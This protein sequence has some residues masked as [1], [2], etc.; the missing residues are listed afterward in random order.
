[1]SE[2]PVKLTDTPFAASLLTNVP[3]ALPTS[4]TSSPVNGLPSS[5]L[6]APAVIVACKT[7]VP[8][9]AAV[10]LPSYSFCEADSPLMVSA[11]VVMFAVAVGAPAMVSE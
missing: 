7:G 5:P 8:V 6:P 11:L 10:K 2:S 3:M 1:M 4:E 9:T